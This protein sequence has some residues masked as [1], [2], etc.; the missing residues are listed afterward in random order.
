MR[1][2]AARRLIQMLPVL[3]I[4]VAI[5]FGLMYLS[6]DPVILMLPEDATEED[7]AALRQALNLDKPFYIQFGTYLWNVLQG[8]FGKSFRY[9]QDA[10]GLVL[11][12][13]PATFQLA[14]VS[15]I[16]AIAI[17]IPLG[18][19]SA[20]RR[21]SVLELFVTTGTVLGKAMPHFWVGIMLVLLFGIELQWFPV[22]GSG[23]LAHMILPALTLGTSVSAYIARL[24]RSSL[25]ESLNQ[26]YVRT[27]RSKGLRP[28]LVVYKHA[29]RNALI[30]VV[31]I[32]MMQT[33]GLV[34]GALITESI[35]A[36]P[37]LGQLLVQSI[38]GRDMAVV[39]A[40]ICVI[41]LLV[42][43]MNLITDLL[44]GWLDPRIKYR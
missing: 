6:G 41:A 16:I 20:T 13:L 10:L 40:A 15:M 32:I 27:A 26:D 25:L 17:A 7:R 11:E 44:V 4:I 35:F 3:F 34:G 30:P 1:Q 36:W 31:T 24:T 38:N 43:A 18:I 9:N 28:S 21:N 39:Q 22:S 2:Y 37:G 29:L 42:I 5:V 23:T 12:R 14:A 33:G 19:L 8:D